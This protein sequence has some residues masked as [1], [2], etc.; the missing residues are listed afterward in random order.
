MQKIVLADT[1]T[2]R[3]LRCKCSKLQLQEFINMK[4]RNRVEKPCIVTVQSKHTMWY[5]IDRRFLE[6][7][8]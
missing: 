5:K 2:E 8:L 7:N 1:S 3:V 4:R 6:T